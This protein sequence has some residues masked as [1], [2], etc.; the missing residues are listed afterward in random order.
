M[1]LPNRL[2]QTPTQTVGPYFAIGL[3]PNRIALP[4]APWATEEIATEEAE[5]D[6]VTLLGR[7]L[8]G[9]GMPVTDALIEARQRNARGGWD[10]AVG[11]TGYGRAA[12]DEAGQFRFR[13]IRPGVARD[14]EAPHLWLIVQA[15]G[16]LG[17]LVTRAHFADETERNARDPVLA[18]VPVARRATLLAEPIAPGLY[19]FD[20]RLQG[21]NETV[22]FDL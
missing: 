12:T 21:P 17:P 19:R 14:D 11:F 10:A 8:D 9:D 6:R 2:G 20:I 18:A 5:G 13:T 22:F 3:V 4:F 1:S 16:L 15:R 7:V